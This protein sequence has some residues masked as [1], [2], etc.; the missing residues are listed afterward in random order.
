MV[1]LSHLPF[2]EGACVLVVV[3]SPLHVLKNCQP[4]ARCVLLV[5]FRGC[6]LCGVCCVWCS[7]GVVS[8]FCVVGSVFCVF[9]GVGVGMGD[10][11]FCFLL[12]S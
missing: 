2:F 4:S 8:L 3:L 12:L 9:I 7:S 5:V 1:V 10:P 6:S 11:I